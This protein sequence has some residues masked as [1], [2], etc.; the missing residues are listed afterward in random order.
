M[1][2][3]SQASEPEMLAFQYVGDTSLTA[4]GSITGKTYRFAAKGAVQMVHR[5]DA[6][7]LRDVPN[8]VQVN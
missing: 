5:Q 7:R 2:Q 6:V 1:A 4:T 3:P 8:L